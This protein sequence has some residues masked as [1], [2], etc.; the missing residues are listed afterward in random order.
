MSKAILAAGAALF[1]IGLAL[2][3]A[4]EKW[5]KE[6]EP[7]IWKAVH[8]LP[9]ATPWQTCHRHFRYDTTRIAVGPGNIVYCYVPYYYLYGP[10]QSRQNFNQ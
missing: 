4:A 7:R 8:A 10:G 1:L 2:P 6:V 3:A 9:G 5:F